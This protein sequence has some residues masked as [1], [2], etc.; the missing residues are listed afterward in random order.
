[1]EKSAL[2]NAGGWLARRAAMSGERVALIEEFAHGE[3]D[4]GPGGARSAMHR[5]LDYRTLEERCARCAAWLRQMGVARGDRVA[6]LLAN[7]AAFLETVFAAARLGAIALPINTRLAPPELR[8]IFDD[9]EPRVLL[10]EAELEERV[11]RA[12]AGMTDPPPQP[13][14]SGWLSM[15]PVT[16]LAPGASVNDGVP[17]LEKRNWFSPA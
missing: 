14:P 10:Y 1:M 2:H 15:K 5:T 9:A 12:C 13:V 4:I 7:R 16:M 6:I 3:S 11:A 17:L 8:Q